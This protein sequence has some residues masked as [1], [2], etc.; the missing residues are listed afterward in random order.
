MDVSDGH[1]VRSRG[2][3]HRKGRQMDWLDDDFDFDYVDPAFLEE[4]ELAG[5]ATTMTSTT[6]TS[7]TTKATT[8][9]RRYDGVRQHL[10]HRAAACL[11]RSRGRHEGGRCR[12]VAARGGSL[13]LRPYQSA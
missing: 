11:Q 1:E 2:S 13:S 6:M 4:D 5:W 10:G 8:I 7:I 12:C 9:R 3:F